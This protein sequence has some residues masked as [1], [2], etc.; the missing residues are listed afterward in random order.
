MKMNKKPSIAFI[1]VLLTVLPLVVAACGVGRAE[2]EVP[3][4]ASF[5]P[6]QTEE[7]PPASDSV[8]PLTPT[9]GTPVSESPREESTPEPEKEPLVAQPVWMYIPALNVDAEIQDTGT[10][11]ILDSMEIFPSGSIISWWRES[12]IPGNEGNA[13]FGGH[14]RWGGANGQLLYLDTLEIGDELEIVY[15]DGS[16]LKFRLESVFVYALATAPGSVIMD[17]SGDARVTIIT[18]KDPFNPRTGTSDN[19]IIAIFK[20]ED[21]FVIPDPPILPFPLERE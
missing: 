19:R 17:V 10:D 13:I 12:A 7:S 8:A 11:Y 3:P 14:N 18:C 4:S 6:E 5:F 15:A 21:G 1:V 16:N 2:A 9:S 20:P